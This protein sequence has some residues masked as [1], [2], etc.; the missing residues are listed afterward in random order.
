MNFEDKIND[1]QNTEINHRVVYPLDS[2]RETT[3]TRDQRS[4][5][6]SEEEFTTAFL[7]FARF[8]ICEN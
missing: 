4:L 2:A 8:Y 1:E 7:T 6:G 3:A 5:T